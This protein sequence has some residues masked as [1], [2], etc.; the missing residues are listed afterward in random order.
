VTKALKK[1]LL[2]EY[3]KIDGRAYQ[4]L[5]EHV[6]KGN[7]NG[8]KI[9]GAWW[10]W[11]EE[12]STDHN[13]TESGHNGPT[14]EGE[15]E[16]ENTGI[17]DLFKREQDLQAHLQKQFE[18]LQSQ[19]IKQFEEYSNRQMV[20]FD[21]YAHEKEESAKKIE[22]LIMIQSRERTE[23]TDKSRKAWLWMVVVVAI[24]VICVASIF[25]TVISKMDED[26][27]VSIDSLRKDQQ[28]TIDSV[29]EISKSNLE[30]I[31]AQ[32]KAE[33]ER[34]EQLRKAETEKLEQ[35]YQKDLKQQLDEMAT[36]KEEL[37]EITQA[38]SA[39]NTIKSSP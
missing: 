13:G 29:K 17:V 11:I 19:Q 6:K 28:I 5:L 27:R 4:T 37:K 7:I 3:Q 18:L 21:K 15:K 20:Q 14:T 32:H 16:P 2:S 10:V 36:L 35:Q 23:Q 8:N 26:Q 39:G 12:A 22:N 24:V 1:M 9:D 25:M 34:L 31:T 38:A 33:M 30:A